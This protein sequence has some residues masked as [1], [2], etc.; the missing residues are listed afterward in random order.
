MPNLEGFGGVTGFQVRL[1]KEPW[2]QNGLSYDDEVDLKDNPAK[3]LK[4]PALRVINPAWRRAIVLRGAR[5]DTRDHSSDTTVQR[6]RPPAL[7]SAS[8]AGDGE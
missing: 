6:L 5:Q 1:P 3:R 7:C 4:R 2:E 8:F